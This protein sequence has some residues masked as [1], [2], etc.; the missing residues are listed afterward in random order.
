MGFLDFLRGNTRSIEET[1]IVSKYGEKATYSAYKSVEK[2]KKSRFKETENINDLLLDFYNKKNQENIQVELFEKYYK[3]SKENINSMFLEEQQVDKQVDE[4]L[5]GEDKKTKDQVKKQIKEENKDE[6]TKNKK[7]DLETRIYKT[8]YKNMY[9]DYADKVLQYKDNQFDDMDVALKDKQA[10]ETLA[11]E[12]NLEKVELMY[13]NKTGKNF[14]SDKKIT[15][16]R[17]DFKN[18]FEYNQRGIEN[19]TDDRMQRINMLYKI[20]EEKYREYINALTDKTKSPQEKYLYKKEYEK[21]N[22]DLIQNVPSLQ[23]YL[24]ELQSQE[25]NEDLARKKGLENKSAVNSRFD[26]KS[27]KNL[28]KSEKVTES[29]TAEF[30]DKSTIEQQQREVKNLEYVNNIQESELDKGN[31]FTAHAIQNAQETK[32]IANKNINESPQKDVSDLKEEVQKNEQY[33]NRDFINDL[34]S[35]VKSGMT[36]EEAKEAMRDDIKEKNYDENIKS[37]EDEYVL[38]RKKPNG[39]K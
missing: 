10:F 33:N 6:K 26:E 38:Q 19:T 17:K 12:K 13:Y 16:Q 4:T 28:G 7:D 24:N 2:V 5:K 25:K 3:M 15:E 14:S 1:F 32:N 9:R 29:S 22:Y 27:F 35:E 8:M 18:K 21:A 31:T 36:L 20:R 23:E 39:K 34:R 11:L 37:Q 30:I